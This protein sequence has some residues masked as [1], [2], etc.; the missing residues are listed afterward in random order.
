MSFSLVILA[1][2]LSTRYGRPKQL[3]PV[4]PE[5][6]A[7]LDYA[8]H[9]AWLAGFTKI[10][11]VIRHEQESAFRDHAHTVYGDRV[12]VAFAYQ[13]MWDLPAVFAP[14]PARRRPWGTGHAVLAARDCVDGPFAVCNADDYY[15]ASAYAALADFFRNVVS[16]GDPS[17]AMVGFTLRNTLSPSGGVSRG[18]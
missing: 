12:D 18:I 3:E 2:G 16:T 5:G 13:E 4:G 14:P 17:F 8:V 6:E 15:G 9:D 7:L 1:A 10:V 11:F